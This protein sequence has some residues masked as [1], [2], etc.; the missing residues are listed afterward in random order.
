LGGAAVR[1][2]GADFMPTTLHGFWEKDVIEEIGDDPAP[3][4][5]DLISSVSQSKVAAA[6]SLG[7]PLDWAQEA[8]RL[9]RNRAYGQ[10]PA[11]NPDGSF[12]LKAEYVTSAIET[13]RTQLAKAG[14]RLAA[15]L[16]RALAK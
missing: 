10:L 12:E 5:E 1:V 8:F 3:I 11:A 7:S 14:V 2:T 13:T 16:N 6:W 4:A 15:T 9:A